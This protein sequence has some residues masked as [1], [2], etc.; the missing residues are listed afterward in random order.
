M[1]GEL[2]IIIIGFFRWLLKGCKTDLKSEI[3]GDKNSDEN[4]R[5]K[6]YLIG[7]LVVII[8]LTILTRL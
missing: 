8:I 1:F 5:G 7:I 3:K 4:I 2:L 6:N